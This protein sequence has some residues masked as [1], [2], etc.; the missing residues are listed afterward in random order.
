[1]LNLQTTPQE[2]LQ[3]DETLPNSNNRLV[4][5]LK[6]S[7]IPMQRGFTKQTAPLNAAL[8]MQEV[9]RDAGIQASIV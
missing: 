6:G 5:T 3:G 9:L 7:Q 2:I 8:I 4:P 1:M